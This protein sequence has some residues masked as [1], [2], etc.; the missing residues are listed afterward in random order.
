[1]E[2]HKT[3]MRFSKKL[4]PLTI[5]NYIL[6]LLLTLILSKESGAQ[7][8]DTIIKKDVYTSY[9]SYAMKSPL[10]VMYYLYQGGGDCSRKKLTFKSEYKSAVNK[11]YIKSGYDRG[12]LVNAEDFAFDCEKEKCTFSYYNCMAQHPTLN[13]GSWKSWETTIRKES[14]FNILKIYTGA[15]YGIS[16]IG[17]GVRVPEHC[18]KVVYNTKTKLITH[19]L[20]F[21]ND[22]TEAVQRVTLSQLKN[23][24]HYPI[25]FNAE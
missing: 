14:Q 4:Y 15:I 7:H 2:S 13:R 6:P 18:W 16:T 17:N 25:E 10:Y 22:E 19:I 24:L 12:H 21:K 3:S 11:D 20:L 1:M 5:C 23:L 8:I 9:Y